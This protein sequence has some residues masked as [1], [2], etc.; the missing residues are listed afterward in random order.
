MSRMGVDF[1]IIVPTFRRPRR[2]QECLE[3]LVGLDFPPDRYEI[4]VVDDGG[5]TDL[6]PIIHELQ[7]GP[8]I[9]LI[10]QQN[11][12]PAAARNGGAKAARG[13]MLAFT[14]DDCRPDPQWLRTFS[15]H[16][17]AANHGAMLGGHTV[18]VLT[19]NIYA[20]AS[21][22]LIDYLYTYYNAGATGKSFFTSNNMAVRRD[23]FFELG[24]FSTAY[25]RAAGEDRDLCD[26]WQ[27]AGYS[28]QYIP[29]AVVYHAH[30]M[31]VRD[32]L[33]QHFNYGRAA[34]HYHKSRREH[35]NEG[36][37]PEPAR[38]YID[39]IRFPVKQDGGPRS[40][41]ESGLMAV[42]QVAN[43]AGYYWD[44]WRSHRR[45]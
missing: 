1:S 11:A 2:L 26:K 5:D 41:M 29:E 22:R 38:F 13:E 12:G 43:A 27:R 45:R 7:R 25:R 17:E 37:T 31:D 33:R 15:R 36:N 34:Y 3:A 9:R 10:R 28:L 24:G 23:L 40:W 4:V 6:T 39:L 30:D 42:S 44:M 32:F 19:G 35:H 14:D 18:N 20:S 16:T 21:Q 8:E